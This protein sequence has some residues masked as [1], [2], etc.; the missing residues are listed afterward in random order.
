[1][2]CAKVI[3]VGQ[4]SKLLKRSVT[5]GR[6]NDLDAKSTTCRFTAF[7]DGLSVM[8][9]AYPS[10]YSRLKKQF[11][12]HEVAT[13]DGLGTHVAVVA[14]KY[15]S[16]VIAFFGTWFIDAVGGSSLS[17]HKYKAAQI[18]AIAARAYQNI[19]H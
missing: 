18:A 7:A 5:P 12:G 4:V 16:E 1:L 19:S 10:D 15:Q 14:G 9:N 6:S 3:T 13:L 17:S 2:Q 8:V 11:P